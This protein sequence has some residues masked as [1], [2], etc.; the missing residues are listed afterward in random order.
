MPRISYWIS[1]LRFGWV[2][3]L[4]L[5]RSNGYPSGTRLNLPPRP[6][7]YFTALAAKVGYGVPAKTL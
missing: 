7:P 1:L 5:H 3:L 2:P 4:A 6:L